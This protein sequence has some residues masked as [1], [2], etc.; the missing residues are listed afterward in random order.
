MSVVAQDA[1]RSEKSKG[2]HEQRATFVKADCSR[3]TITFKT[4]E[5][6]G[7]I[8]ETT[9][10]LSK[11]AKILGEKGEIE[12]LRQLA[13]NMDKEKDKSI[14]ITEDMTDKRIVQVKDLPTK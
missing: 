9:L 4:A 1:K 12:T 11:G 7:K 2:M 5:K 3:N 8:V 10:P 14:W 6:S 13:D